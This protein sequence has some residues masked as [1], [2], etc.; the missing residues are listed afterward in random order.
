M[1]EVAD[2]S[3]QAAG[4]AP[5]LPY[6]GGGAQYGDDIESISNNSAA[7]SRTKGLQYNIGIS[8]PLFQWGALKNQ[9]ETEKALELISKKNYAEAYR[10]LTLLLRSRYLGVIIDKIGLRNARF[11]LKLS[12]GALALANEKLKNGTIASGDIITPQM[13][14]DEKQLRFD[15]L[16]QTYAFDRRTL[17]RAIGWKD[18]PDESVPL[19]IPEPKYSPAVADEILAALLREGAR[20]TFQAQIDELNIRQNDLAYKIAS[21]RLLPKFSA[22]AGYQIENQAQASHTAIEQTTLANETFYNGASCTLF[23]GFAARAATG[24]A[25]SNRRYYEKQLEIVTES[26]MD[27]AQ[28]DRRSVDFGWRALRLAHRRWDLATAQKQRTMDELKLGNVS[29]SE[30]D[31]ATDALNQG[32]FD[33]RRG[34]GGFSLGLERFRVNGGRRSRDEQTARPLCPRYPLSPASASNSSPSS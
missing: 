28:N 11:A 2:A 3:R 26:T 14:A 19:E 13:E 30:V 17:A 5:L 10:S 25:V 12:Q 7:T 1:I 16:E 29:Q 24:A 33:Q 21:V 18:I 34:P 4:V 6:L 31:G 27:Q 20:N 32:E 9:L 15:R 22:T 8:Q 23:D